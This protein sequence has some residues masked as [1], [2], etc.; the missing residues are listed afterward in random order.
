M[1]IQEATIYMKLIDIE[2]KLDKLLEK[3]QSKNRQDK[4]KRIKGTMGDKPYV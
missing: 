4:E 1:G 3:G 2:K